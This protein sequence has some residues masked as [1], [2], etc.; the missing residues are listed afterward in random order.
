MCKDGRGRGGKRGPARSGATSAWFE[1]FRVREGV[2]GCI[3]ELSRSLSGSFRSSEIGPPSPLSDRFGGMF[4][5]KG[6]RS[7]CGAYRTFAEALVLYCHDGRCALF[8]EGWMHA[9]WVET[10]RM[11]LRNSQSDTRLLG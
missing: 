3:R 5:F 4:D 9:A 8:G 6:G 7:H 1:E 2:P 10:Q 11:R